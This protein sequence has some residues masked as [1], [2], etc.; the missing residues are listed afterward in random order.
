MMW[1]SERW[2]MTMSYTHTHVDEKTGSDQTHITIAVVVVVI[3]WVM[4]WW[5]PAGLMCD[6]TIRWWWYLP[7]A[8]GTRRWWLG[9]WQWNLVPSSV[10]SSHLQLVSMM[11]TMY[12]ASLMMPLPASRSS[13]M[14]RGVYL[15]IWTGMLWAY[16]E[17]YCSYSE[18]CTRQTSW[19]YR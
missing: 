4:T 17:C 7:V 12:I 5:R 1:C 10:W 6:V 15:S 8:W 19:W 13:R 3:V 2:M 11:D 18:S 14:I 16:W 9:C